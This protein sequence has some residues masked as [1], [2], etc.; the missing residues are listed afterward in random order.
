M[1]P[2]PRVGGWGVVPAALLLIVIGAPV[3][4][5]IALGALVLGAVSQ[6]DDRRGLSARS[7]FIA[8]IAVAGAAVAASVVHIDAWLAAIAVIVV[9]WIVNLYNFMDG[10]NGLAGGMAV[11]GFATYAIGAAPSQPQLSL[12]GAAVAGAGLGFLILNFNPA[13]V[14]LGDIGSVPLGF[15]AGA[16][17]FWGWQHGAWPVWFPALAFAPFFADATATLLRRLARRERVWEAH[18]EHYYQRLVQLGASHVR[19]ALFYYSLMVGGSAIALIAMYLSPIVQWALVI[20]W[21]LTLAAV[22]G[23]IDLRWNAFQKSRAAVPR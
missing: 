16:M 10:S 1:K 9:V 17:G 5:W 11:F 20:A 8:H 12:A 4:R 13:R 6:I 18:R 3:L 23:R 15:L 14:F 19:V 2:I 21:Y 22:G 7:R